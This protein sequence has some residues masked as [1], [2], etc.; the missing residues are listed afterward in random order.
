MDV[1]NIKGVLR[2]LNRLSKR[3]GRR[4]KVSVIVGYTAS[5]ALKVH[6]D[7]N[8]HHEV[9]QAKYLE[10]P[11]RELHP[12]LGENVRKAVLRGATLLHGLYLA[13][14]PIQRESQKLVPIDTGNLKAS[15]FTRKEQP[16]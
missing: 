1:V 6:E 14:L 13:G 11:A 2:Q 16:E 10:Q 8:S 5:Y 7:L 12:I 3:Y 9:G 4:D 15:A